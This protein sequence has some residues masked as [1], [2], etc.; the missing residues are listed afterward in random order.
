M[1]TNVS[2]TLELPFIFR[3]EKMVIKGTMSIPFS[4]GAVDDLAEM[5]AEI[6]KAFRDLGFEMGSEE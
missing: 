3:S 2:V 1:K 4:V 6:Y 5:I